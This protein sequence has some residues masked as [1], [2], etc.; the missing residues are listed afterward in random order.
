MPNLSMKL[1]L[2]AKDV[3]HRVVG[4]PNLTENLFTVNGQVSGEQINFV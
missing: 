4:E 3:T 2:S 1:S